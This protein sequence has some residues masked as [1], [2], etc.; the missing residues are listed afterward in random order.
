M[1]QP[2][3]SAFWVL[4][5]FT[6]Y[7]I[8]FINT[9][10]LNRRKYIFAKWY[11]QVIF[12]LPAL[13]TSFFLINPQDIIMAVVLGYLSF[14]ALTDYY[15]KIIYRIGHLPILIMAVV[16]GISNNVDWF[17]LIYFYV[18]L[19]LAAFLKC[20]AIGDTLIFITC[21]AI[22]TAFNYETVNLFIYWAMS[23]FFFFMVN[24]SKIKVNKEADGKILL[25]KDGYPVA[26]SIYIGFIASILIHESTAKYALPLLM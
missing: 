14:C 17:K 11:K 4:I 15:D 8:F 7:R 16:Y 20:Y 26:P 23:I 25:L 22:L 6:I 5:S 12:L 1:Y 3:V 10:A 13:L 24:I 18:F 21:G 19:A 2:F 9:S